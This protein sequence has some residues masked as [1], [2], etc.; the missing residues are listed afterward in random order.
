MVGAAPVPCYLI[1]LSRQE[2]CFYPS[3]STLRGQLL[4]LEHS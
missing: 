3:C 2:A 4:I 1:D